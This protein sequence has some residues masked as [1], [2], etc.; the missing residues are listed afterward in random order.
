MDNVGEFCRTTNL[1]AAFLIH[2]AYITFCAAMV[3][4]FY[5]L[6]WQRGSGFDAAEF[7]G[8]ASRLATSRFKSLL[9]KAII[10]GI[11]LCGLL[12]WLACWGCGINIDDQYSLR[13]NPKAYKE[14]MM[15]IYMVF[16]L[17]SAGVFFVFAEKGTHFR[18]A[19]V[20]LLILHAILL[21]PYVFAIYWSKHHL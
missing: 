20:S 10:P 19:I 9:I 21:A 2:W 8:R 1:I 16:Y 3:W 7:A 15:G 5:K 11:G 12:F 18:Q 6:A 4:L 17:L 14:I 13:A